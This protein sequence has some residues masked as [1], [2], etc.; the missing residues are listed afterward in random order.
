MF[1]KK[2][3][4]AIIF[5]SATATIGIAGYL[6]FTN[7]P[8]VLAQSAAKI[9]YV[10]L[11]GNDGND[12]SSGAPFKTIQK[13]ADRVGP[14]ARVIVKAGVYNEKISINAKSGTASAPYCL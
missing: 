13:A 5:S 2:F 4:A 10:S 1:F 3:L 8:S 9:Y 12:G 11:S 6:Y 7:Q 14:G